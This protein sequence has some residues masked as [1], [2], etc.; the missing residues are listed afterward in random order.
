MQILK[1]WFCE[2]V[3]T[4]GNKIVFKCRSEQERKNLEA[5]FDKH[6][7]KVHEDAEKAIELER[8]LS[9]KE[10]LIEAV[11]TVQSENIYVKEEI[12]EL[13]SYIMSIEDENETLKSLI[14]LICELHSKEDWE[15]LHGLI[16][17]L[18]NQYLKN[19]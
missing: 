13:E 11:Q 1:H 10:E 17:T 6:F 2:V 18:S 14:A 16:L 8:I 3:Y 4:I 5:S 12:S 7:K 9:K 19:S 15:N